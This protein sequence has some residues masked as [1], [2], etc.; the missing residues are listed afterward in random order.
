MIEGVMIL[1]RCFKFFCGILLFLLCLPV[2]Q[3]QEILHEMLGD[4]AMTF[5]LD[6]SGTVLE[7]NFNN[8]M[9]ILTISASEVGNI[10]P[11]VV[12]IT[13]Y[14]QMNERN[15]FI[16]DSEDSYMTYSPNTIRCD[17]RYSYMNEPSNIH[18]F[19]ASP[20][21]YEREPEGHFGEHEKEESE[22]LADKV[23]LPTKVIAQAGRLEFTIS[24]NRVSGNVWIKGY[25]N[26]ENSYVKYFASFR[27]RTIY[28]VDP[29]FPATEPHPM[30]ILEQTDE[31]YR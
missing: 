25:D 3:S 12:R 9:A 5:M 16:W 20:A 10:N 24:G 8:S 14:P 13:G 31:R 17:I 11:Y 18:F 19:Y 26:V 23:L 2:A 6:M 15:V 21:L 27:G 7:K 1:R 30:Y 28:Q 29:R 22:R 4:D